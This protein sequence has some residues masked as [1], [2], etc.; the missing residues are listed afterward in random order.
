M[1]AN[2][3][4][5]ATGR[6]VPMSWMSHPF[7]RP[8]VAALCLAGLAAGCA[9]TAES[10]AGPSPVLSVG[11]PTQDG[12]PVPAPDPL[13]PVSALGATKFLAFGDS[14]TCG[15]PGTF[16]QFDIAFDDQFCSPPGGSPQYPQMARSLLQQASPTQAIVVDNEGRPGE[17]VRLALSRFTNLVASRRPQGVLLLE[18]INDLNNPDVY[19]NPT[20][21]IDAAVANLLRLIDL[22]RVY[23]ATVLVATMFQTCYSENPYTLRVRENSA[24]LI[25]PFN[26]ALRAAVAGRLNV[27]VVDLYASFGTGNCL[28]DRGTNYVGEDGLHPSP[29]GYSRIASAFANAVRDK[30]AVRGSFQ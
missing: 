6:P 14:I 19:A 26:N 8:V 13:P 25:V 18:G 21:R 15:T 7:R 24:N 20:Q 9:G 27:H 2:S 4:P 1:Y 23:N 16:P 3:L 28:P 11:S 29:S 12:L 30:F 17:E 22:A 5:A 10:P